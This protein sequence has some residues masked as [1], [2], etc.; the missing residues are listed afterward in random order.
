MKHVMTKLFGLLLVLSLSTS[1]SAN[2]DPKTNQITQAVQS[3]ITS[4]TTGATAVGYWAACAETLGA[5]CILAA[6]ATVASM[7]SGA[8]SVQNI[9]D[10]KDLESEEGGAALPD[11][12]NSEGR[13]PG[14]PTLGGGI[15]LNRIKDAVL[16]KIELAQSMMEE[17]KNKGLFSDEMLAHPEKFLTAEEL[18]QFN[19]EKEKM[20]AGLENGA[21]ENRDPQEILQALL[22]ESDSQ[23]F[24]TASF[25]AET[26]SAFNLSSFNLESLLNPKD[27]GIQNSAPGYYGNVSL[28][29]L[30]PE[31]KL[32]LFERVSLKIKKVM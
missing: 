13:F 10:A 7:A 28:K 27:Q 21:E 6:A 20:M 15:P 4:L 26:G 29:S 32:S 2:E 30:R 24:Q 1:V 9:M 12:F 16:Q 25:T 14:S 11:S 31:S 23:G 3:G 17:A 8:A 22:E 5:T 18:A 19:A